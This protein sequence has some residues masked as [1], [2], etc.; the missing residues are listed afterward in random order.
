[1]GTS[2]PNPH[3]GTVSS[4]LS[5]WPV[6][7]ENPSTSSFATKGTS[8]FRSLSRKQPCI[9]IPPGKYRSYKPGPPVDNSH[10]PV[11]TYLLIEHFVGCCSHHFLLRTAFKR[12]QLRLV[13]RRAVR[14]D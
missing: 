2:R 10:V 6:A 7:A 5:T 11:S 12:H 13:H 9:R 1:M 14:I 4:R 8:T 3:P